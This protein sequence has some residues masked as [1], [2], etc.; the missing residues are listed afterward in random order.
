MATFQ[1]RDVFEFCEQLYNQLHQQDNGYFPQKHDVIVFQKAALKFNTSEEAAEKAYSSYSKLAA[2]LEMIKINRLPKNKRQDVMMRKMQ[3]IMLNN[4]DLPFYKV[5]GEPST[6]IPL[7]MDVIEEEFSESIEK[8]A[9]SGWT[10]PLTIDIE[11][12][13]ELKTCASSQS[14]IDCFFDKFYSNEELENLF[15]AIRESI[16]NAGQKKRFEECCA[17]FKQGFYS[18]CLTTLTTILEG[19]ISSFGDDPSDVRVMRICDFHAGKERENG[20]KIKALCW[21]SIYEYIKLLFEKSDFSQLEPN[22]T[23]RHWLVHGRTSQIGNKID[24][25]RIFNALAILSSL[26]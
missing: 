3:D 16:S 24:C 10:I 17:I 8:I 22:E 21:K 18:T 1:N 6:P 20:N 11:R 14:D 4:K 13:D 23:N 15:I 9:Q 12:L 2:K 25:I 26:N 5:E 7:A 19:S